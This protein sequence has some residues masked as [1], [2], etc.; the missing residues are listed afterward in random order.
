M[1]VYLPFKVKDRD[2][3]RE[4]SLDHTTDS[5][6]K[7]HHTVDKKSLLITDAYERSALGDVSDCEWEEEAELLCFWSNQLTQDL[8]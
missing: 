6:I 5:Q 8:I 2:E 7:K 1:C 3:E 4:S